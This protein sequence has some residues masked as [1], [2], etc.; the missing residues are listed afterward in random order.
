MSTMI[1][2][3]YKIHTHYLHVLAKQGSVCSKSEF[4]C[5]DGTCIHEIWQCDG[6]KDCPDNSD[7]ID[8][9][10]FIYFL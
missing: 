6:D 8:C 5:K 7:E 3:S 9:G 10:E 1:D 2:N 4:A